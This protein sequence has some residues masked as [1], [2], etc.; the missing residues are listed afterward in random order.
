MPPNATQSA[1]NDTIEERREKRQRANEV[2]QT[3][4][5]HGEKDSLPHRRAATPEEREPGRFVPRDIFAGTTPVGGVGVYRGRPS[6][7]Q[8]ELVGIVEGRVGWHVLLVVVRV[9]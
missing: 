1:A 9:G 4:K 8:G 6:A 7:N 2:E 3:R 5:Q